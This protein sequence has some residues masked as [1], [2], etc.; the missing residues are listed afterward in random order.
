MAKKMQCNNRVEYD[1][2]LDKLDLIQIPIINNRPLE[3]EEEEPT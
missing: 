1:T 3:E 2:D